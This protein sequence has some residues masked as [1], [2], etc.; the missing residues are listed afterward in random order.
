MS[1]SYKEIYNKLIG[2]K[3]NTVV[4]RYSPEKVNMNIVVLVIMQKKCIR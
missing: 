3:F 2:E 1:N 4:I